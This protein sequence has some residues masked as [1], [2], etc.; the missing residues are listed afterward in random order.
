M[1][2]NEYNVNT[3]NNIYSGSKMIA[4]FISFFFNIDANESS[5]LVAVSQEYRYKYCY[6]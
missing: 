4:T 5:I 6:I 1:S 3:W 2:T